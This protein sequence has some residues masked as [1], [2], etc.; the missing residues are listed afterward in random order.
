MHSKSVNCK[1]TEH[2]SLFALSVTYISVTDG[3]A[4]KNQI[5]DNGNKNV[6]NQHIFQHILLYIIGNNDSRSLGFSYSECFK[7]KINRFLFF[8]F[9]KQDLTFSKVH[10]GPSTLSAMSNPSFPG[11]V[12]LSCCCK[13]LLAKTKRA[14][15]LLNSIDLTARETIYLL[16]FRSN[17]ISRRYGVAGRCLGNLVIERGRSRTF[18][19]SN[20]RN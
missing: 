9:I 14:I 2:Q 18:A 16:T 13:R 12:D 20:L 1:N 3:A 7:D 8:F 10:E 6:S 4:Y 15:P 17:L 5:K 11:D 19:Q